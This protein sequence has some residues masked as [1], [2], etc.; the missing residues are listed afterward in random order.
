MKVLI[1]P[2]VLI[3]Q[4]KRFLY[5]REK[6]QQ[7]KD[8]SVV[9]VP[10]RLNFDGESYQLISR[11]SHIGDSTSS[12]H[13]ICQIAEKKTLNFVEINNTEIVKR[14]NLNK[15]DD[16]EVYLCFYEKTQ[17]EQVKYI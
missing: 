15:Q 16:Q 17:A 12:G 4:L 10:Q 3:L 7:K 9:T 13:Y 11:I 5:D 8:L 14:K 6:K 2:Q 1:K